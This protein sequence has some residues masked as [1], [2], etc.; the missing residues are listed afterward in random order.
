MAINHRTMAV[1]WAVII[2]LSIVLVC[3]ITGEHSTGKSG[4]EGTVKWQYVN[5]RQEPSTD[6]P[7]V[8]ELSHGTTITLTGKVFTYSDGPYRDWVEVTS[9]SGDEG[10]VVAESVYGH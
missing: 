3:T 6:A 10:W 4:E 7:I 9:P 2:L 5:L 1:V 8:Q